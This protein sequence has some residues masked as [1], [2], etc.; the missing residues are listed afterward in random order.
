MK[1]DEQASAAA[2]R[3]NPQFHRFTEDQVKRVRCSES[4]TNGSSNHHLES[5]PA[6]FVTMQTLITPNSYI[7]AQ[8]L[9]AYRILK[10]NILKHKPEKKQT[11]SKIHMFTTL[12]NQ[13]EEVL[14]TLKSSNLKSQHAEQAQI[15]VL[16]QDDPRK[17]H[18]GSFSCS[19]PG[20]S[21]RHVAKDS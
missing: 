13:V 12:C 10:I 7:S 18:G 14:P 3:S 16:R 4:K 1:I 5:G 20:R 17:S 9:S 8:R 6:L 2:R 19:L 15:K 11:F 21:P